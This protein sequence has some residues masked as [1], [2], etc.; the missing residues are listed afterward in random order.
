[1]TET[2]EEQRKDREH[3][4]VKCDLIGKQKGEKQT[5]DWNVDM[6]LPLNKVKKIK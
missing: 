3:K 6:T 4:I 5:Y 1:M 2:K